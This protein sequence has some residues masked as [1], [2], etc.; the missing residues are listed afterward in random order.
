MVVL[1]VKK[2]QEGKSTAAQN[3]DKENLA[4]YAEEGQ[5]D[6]R[7]L[8]TNI[9]SIFENANKTDALL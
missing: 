6:V 4:P 1:P 3:N 8:C 5:I 2:K 7:L 9:I